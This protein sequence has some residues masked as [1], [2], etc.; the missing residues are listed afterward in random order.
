MKWYRLAAKQG[1]ADA[2]FKLGYMYYRGR[3]VPQDFKEAAKWFKLATEQ[4]DSNAQFNLG[5]M[6]EQG[7]GVPQSNVMAYM[8]LDVATVNADTKEQKTII[9]SRE[10]MT[11]STTAAQVGKAQEL[12]RE[13]ADNKFKGCRGEHYAAAPI[14]GHM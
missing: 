12:T 10:S 6:Y 9:R 11:V 3:G 7:D 8:W 5:L 2:Q 14:A 1:S 13:C 4:G